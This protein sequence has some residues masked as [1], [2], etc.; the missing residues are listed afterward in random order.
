VCPKNLIGSVDLYLTT[1][2]GLFQSNAKVIVNALH[3]RVAIMNNGPH[4][5]G[6]PEAWETVHNSPGLE[7]LWQL[8]S[9][10]DSDKEHNVAESL[11]AN[12]AESCE[13]KYIQVTANLDGSFTVLNSRNGFKKTYPRSVSASPR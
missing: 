2:H 1:H 12:L 7:D 6:S 5:G 8:H 13:G 3:P 4:K 10:L 11:I 9:A